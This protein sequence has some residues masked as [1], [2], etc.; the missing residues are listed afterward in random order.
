M[1]VGR[2][3]GR[4]QLPESLRTQ[5]LDFRRRVWSRKTAQALCVA[6]FGVVV[7]Y[8]AMF[9]S[10][11]AWE[12]PS[13]PRLV[14]FLAAAFGIALIPVAIYRWVWRNQRPDQLARL[15]T[16]KHPHIGDQLLG[17]IEL[18]LDS[19]EQARSR[20]LVE[21]AIEQVARDAQK[22]DFSDA[23][24]SPRHRMWAVLAAV[25]AVA[26]V[27]LMIV[28]P[29]A[30]TNAWARLLAPWS[31]TPRYTFAALEPIPAKMVVPHGETFTVTANL[32][33]G[34]ASRPK[35]AVVQ[36]GTQRSVTAN[37]NNG[38]Y[39]FVLPPQIDKGELVMKV[40]D[41][42]RTI[43][44]EPTLRPELTSVVG[45]VNLPD[46]LQ[47]PGVMK[48]DVRGGTAS[49]V[50]GSKATFTATAGR[51]LDAA[52]V[53]GKPANVSGSTLYS[54]TTL[55]NGPLA[56]EI[57]WKDT[58]GLEGKEPFALTINGRDDEA[59][60]L[61]VEDLPRQRVVLDTEQLTFKVRAQDDF[62]VKLVGIEWKGMEDPTVKTPAKGEKVI[63]AGGPDKDSLDLTGT[64]TAKTLGIEPQQ[65]TLRIYAEDYLPGRERVYSTSYTFFVLNA[66]QHAIW[67]TE[68]LSK[69][70]RQSLE[71][72]DREMQLHE[73]N[74]QI[75]GLTPEQLDQPDTRRRIETQATSER[76][77][78]R[79]LSTL[80]VGGEDLIRQAMRNPEFGVGHLE[81]LGEMLQILK[82]ISGNRMP[83]VAE[84]LKQG[85]QA[86]AMGS[87]SKI[88]GKTAM[89]GQVRATSKGKPGETDP[90]SKSKPAAP[91]I[92][93]RES[94]H[95]DPNKPGEKDDDKTKTKPAAPRL[96]LPVTTLA[97]K[98]GKASPTPD[99][100]PQDDV[101][102]AVK[103]QSDL[104]AEFE[105]IS[106]EMNKV[107]ANLEGSTLVKRLKAA[108]RNQ[109]KIAGRISDNVNET[110]GAAMI[111]AGGAPAKTLA[112]MAEAEAKSSQD[113]SFIMDDMQSY[114]ERRQYV[115]FKSV[116]DDMR[117]Q[118][119]IG[120]LRT[121]GDDL[122]KENGVSIAM[123]EYWS[124][125]L[126]RWSEDLVDPASGGT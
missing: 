103:Q 118:D 44:I 123:A 98:A 4:L 34:T 64:F 67:L 38:K 105:K 37:L 33:K 96:T 31:A 63:A 17:V 76:A 65:I 39:E 99:A 119:V 73:T 86:P 13:G 60:S 95:S 79:R 100:P 20:R 7:A 46:Y 27:V 58:L 45:D 32:A 30:A 12:T 111:P 106:D 81:K 41:A 2:A 56:M 18:A 29:A 28:V 87:A 54:P 101:E 43:K 84:L 116:L 61:G 117:K 59:P 71:V 91:M 102:E 120:G 108:S 69:W 110:F 21:A 89:A 11:R 19:S 74:K 115:N 25:P 82:D 24:P 122:R 42:R 104:L 77:N 72:R 107:L 22:R 68:Q 48:K 93:D 83:S 66:E 75:R 88:E 1:N 125:N 36:L 90:K 62:G 94:Q 85:A 55:V 49:M 40:G 70:H 51:T 8:L 16:R 50:K 109:Y 121:L 92:A 3:D 9:A 57:R 124:D 5:L 78:G 15:L 35:Q 6:A 47:R 112:E 126:D 26:A 10:D 23:V 53:N 52:W 114:F 97:G 14:L 80:V 113:V